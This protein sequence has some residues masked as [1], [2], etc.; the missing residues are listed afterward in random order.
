MG[1]LFFNCNGAIFR[2]RMN[3]WRK[4]FI[5]LL[6]PSSHVK[7][8]KNIYHDVK[9][10]IY[11][12]I[13]KWHIY[14]AYVPRSWF[15][16]SLT[17]LIFSDNW[18]PRHSFFYCYVPCFFIILISHIAGS[19]KDG[20][21]R[22]SVFLCVYLQ[23]RVIYAPFPCLQLCLTGNSCTHNNYPDDI[24]SSLSSSSHT[25]VHIPY[26]FKYVLWSCSSCILKT[27]YV[28]IKNNNKDDIEMTTN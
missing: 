15:C 6:L 10:K 23:I 2:F 27:K 16:F 19:K 12:I 17:S 21:W 25:L 4:H 9:G 11:R 13:N 20:P 18:N 14:F 3:Q 26:N 28:Y 24:T 5:V 22:W 8:C 1:V 7:T